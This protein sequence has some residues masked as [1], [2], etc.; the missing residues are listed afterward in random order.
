MNQ[1]PHNFSGGPGALPE[2]VLE[3][4]AEAIHSVDDCGISVLGMSH[5]SDWFRAVVDEAESHL[6]ALLGLSATQ[7]VVLMQGGGTA[8]FAMIP[9]LLGGKDVTV[10][11]LHTGY[12][13]GKAIAEARKFADVRVPWSGE[14]RGFR[15]LPH[16][17][18]VTFSSE[19]A[20]LHYVSN[21]T[22]EG[23][24]FTKRPGVAGVPLICDMSSDFCSGP[25]EAGAYDLIYAHAQ[26]NLGPA[27]VTVA[28][29]DER[30]L[31]N[32]PDDLPS[33]LDYRPQIAA[34]SIYNTP[35]VF[36]IYAT[37]LVLRWLHD[38]VGGLAAMQAINQRKAEALYQALDQFDDCYAPRAA[39]RDRSPMNVVFNLRRP[40]QLPSFLSAARAAGLHGLE[41]HRSI[42][43]IR[44]SIYN[45][46]SEA[47]VSAL[48][49]FL[50]RQR[51]HLS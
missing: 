45:A 33:V 5:R 22:V 47:S 50:D 38:E 51:P 23:L 13:S 31:A 11:Y 8:Q 14:S 12:W 28:V 1:Q 35:P 19:A 17:D 4:L 9:M 36:A 34:G 41:G 49:D 29:V 6:R 21:E 10:E 44:A 25:I 15:E 3:Q 37:L 20:Y 18:E 24:R 30:L 40:E 32:A 46:V 42:G 43:G 48:I 27:G 39:V 7:R 2:R 16:P 26:K